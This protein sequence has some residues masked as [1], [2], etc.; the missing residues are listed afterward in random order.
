MRMQK[1]NS[2]TIGNYMIAETVIKH[3]LLQGADADNATDAQEQIAKLCKMVLTMKVAIVAAADEDLLAQ[4][5]VEAF[6]GSC[7]GVDL[8]KMHTPKPPSLDKH[9]GLGLIFPR[10]SSLL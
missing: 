3:D 2:T 4:T 9:R 5:F 8:P 7:G 6:L 10:R 1:G